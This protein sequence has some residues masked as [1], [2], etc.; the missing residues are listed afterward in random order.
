MK[1]LPIA[2]AALAVWRLTHLLQAEDG[3][4]EMFARFRK[5][6]RRLSLF[7][8]TDCFYCLSLWVAAPFAM[9]LGSLWEERLT[10]WLALSGAAILAN[11]L[12]EVQPQ[13]ALFYEELN[14]EEKFACR[15][16][17]MDEDY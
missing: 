17:E 2:I 5:W 8:V 3:P 9:T 10:L 1:A 7:D 13:S 15:V 14:R 16:A 6:L 11:R 12:A 4:F